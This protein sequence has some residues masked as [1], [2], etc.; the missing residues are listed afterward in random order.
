MLSPYVCTQESCRVCEIGFVC[1]YVAPITSM[2]FHDW[3]Y[4][5]KQLNHF[6]FLKVPPLFRI[7]LSFSSAGGKIQK[8]ALVS[9]SD[10]PFIYQ[11]PIA[12]KMNV[13]LTHTGNLSSW[14]LVDFETIEEQI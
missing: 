7:K 6:S 1:T 4:P 12:L 2:H 5:R 8:M 10:R 11:A 13:R 14:M 3:T 9:Y